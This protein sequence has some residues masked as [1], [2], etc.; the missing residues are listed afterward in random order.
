MLHHVTLVC[1]R[2][3]SLASR[4]ASL[5]IPSPILL[6]F[7][8]SSALTSTI[9]PHNLPNTAFCPALRAYIYFGP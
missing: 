4:F 1:P 9:Y 7:V 2:G 6:V 3:G 5:N 8:P